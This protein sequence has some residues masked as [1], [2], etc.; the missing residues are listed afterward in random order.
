MFRINKHILWLTQPQTATE[1]L[2]AMKKKGLR[3]CQIHDFNKLFD[4]EKL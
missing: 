1:S 3:F 4:K 2:T